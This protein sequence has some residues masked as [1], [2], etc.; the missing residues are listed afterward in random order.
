[1]FLLVAAIIN[2]VAVI[3]ARDSKN[4]PSDNTNYES[5]SR[6][7]TAKSSAT[8]SLITTGSQ[9]DLQ[10]PKDKQEGSITSDLSNRTGEE[11]TK[12]N[13]HRRILKNGLNILDIVS[14]VLSAKVESAMDKDYS[15]NRKSISSMQN[16]LAVQCTTL[17]LSFSTVIN[18]EL[19][20]IKG[21]N[22]Y[23]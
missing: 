18:L 23:L 10:L 12:T 14:S 3:I 17:Y 20:R 9:K 19:S 13:H 1:M 5:Q 8:A 22:T 21:Q 6:N 15:S 2:I 4:G 11:E 7:A 16:M